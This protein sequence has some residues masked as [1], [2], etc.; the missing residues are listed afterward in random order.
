MISFW[1]QSFLPQNQEIWISFKRIH[2]IFN[3]FHHDLSNNSPVL[4][5]TISFPKTIKPFRKVKRKQERVCTLNLTKKKTWKPAKISFHLQLSLFNLSSA[6]R[7]CDLQT[8]KKCGGFSLA[9]DKLIFLHVFEIIC[10]FVIVFISS[11]LFVCT[12]IEHK[13]FWFCY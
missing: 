11:E 6:K 9:R 8:S 1:L 7:N 4:F 10:C 5:K 3:C 12:G 2:L 13:C